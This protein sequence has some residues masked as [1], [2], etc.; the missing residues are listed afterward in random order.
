MLYENVELLIQRMDKQIARDGYAEMRTDYLALATDNV[1]HY[2]IGQ[3]RGLLQDENGAL[4]WRQ[5]IK[6]LAEWTL[7]ARHFTWVIPF[8]LKIPM[9]PLKMFLPDFA[10]IVGLHRVSAFISHIQIYLKDAH[11]TS[12]GYAGTCPFC[13]PNSY[14]APRRY[15]S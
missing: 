15:D 14:L 10:R 1:S 5:S 6:C 11:P 8:V 7:L 2:S 9:L 13:H 3:P 4:D 12:T